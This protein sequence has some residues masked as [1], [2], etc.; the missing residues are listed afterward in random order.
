MPKTG[1]VKVNKHVE[2]SIWLTCRTCRPARWVCTVC[3][4]R[5]A[6]PELCPVRKIMLKKIESIE[7]ML[8]PAQAIE[9]ANPQQKAYRVHS[10]LNRKP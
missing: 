7:E 3:R 9:T 10:Y 2:K 6:F 1:E 4:K 8:S 5:K